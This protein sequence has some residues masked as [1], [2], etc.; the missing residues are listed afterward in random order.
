MLLVITP[1]NGSRT[2]TPTAAEKRRNGGRRGT[3]TAAETHVSCATNQGG[4]KASK[5]ADVVGEKHQLRHPHGK[6]NS[7]GNEGSRTGRPT[8]AEQGF[9]LEV[10]FLLI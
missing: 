1:D 10:K 4:I 6:T 5:Y 9:V 8:A 2:G 7:G 3:P